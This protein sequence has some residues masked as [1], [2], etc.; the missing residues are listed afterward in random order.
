MRKWINSME[1]TIIDGGNGEKRL[2][3]L[4][5]ENMCLERMKTENNADSNSS[6]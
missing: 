4:E 2:F 6:K 5:R 1:K 3:S